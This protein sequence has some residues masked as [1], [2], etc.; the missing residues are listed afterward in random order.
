MFDIGFAELL[1]IAVVALIVLGPQRLPETIRFVSL[2]LGRL[3]RG[4]SSARKELEQEIGMDEIRRQLHNEDVLRSLEESKRSLE[5]LARDDT[6][7]AGG[8]DRGPKVKSDAGGAEPRVAEPSDPPPAS[9]VD[10][11]GAP[12]DSKTPP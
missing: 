7:S 3:R 1:L 2:W 8:A 10:I 12:G 9:G 6:P 11:T 4:L 5:S